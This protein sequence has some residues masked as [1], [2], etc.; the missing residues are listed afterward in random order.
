MAAEIAKEIA[1]QIGGP[2]FFMM[3]AKALTAGES[4]LTWRLGGGAIAPPRGPAR[5]ESDD[6]GDLDHAGIPR[7][8]LVT[9]CWGCSPLR[10]G[11]ADLDVIVEKRF[12]APAGA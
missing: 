3:G 6:Y 11:G 12:G 1:R 9:L 10:G 8:E 5:C 2:A 4:S 7:G